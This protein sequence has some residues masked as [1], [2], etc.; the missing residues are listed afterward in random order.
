M[1]DFFISYTGA[2]RT[3]A[4]W[5]AWVLEAGGSSNQGDLAAARACY[6]RALEVFA[7]GLGP[8]HPYSETVRANLARLEEALGEAPGEEMR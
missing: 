7:A 2:D 6:S 3:W 4:E 1:T 5:I 8:E